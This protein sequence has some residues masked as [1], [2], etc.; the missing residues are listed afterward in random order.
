LGTSGQ[1]IGQAPLK[2]AFSEAATLFL[3][4]NEPG[5]NYLARLEKQ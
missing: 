2:G 3:R 5:Q 4:G 1:K